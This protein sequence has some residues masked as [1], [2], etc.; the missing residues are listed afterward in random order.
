MSQIQ[1]AVVGVYNYVVI[2]SALY[3]KCLP[4]LCVDTFLHIY[5][6]KKTCYRIA[7]FKLSTK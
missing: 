6:N 7:C 3:L 4:Y 5:Y 1:L 2:L